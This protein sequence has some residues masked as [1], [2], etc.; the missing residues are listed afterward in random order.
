MIHLLIKGYLSAV[1]RMQIVFGLGEPF[2]ASWPLLECTLQ[3]IKL[4]Q[5]KR[6]VT[7]SQPRLP[8]RPSSARCATKRYIRFSDSG[9]GFDF[10][11]LQKDRYLLWPVVYT[12]AMNGA[13]AASIKSL[14]SP[15]RCCMSS[16]P[17][18]PGEPPNLVGSCF[19]PV[20]PGG[21]D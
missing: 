8:C 14:T 11:F 21:R 1:R 19:V 12:R 9:N 5:A 15:S 16:S 20:M 6:A 2:V 18:L 13:I 17:G 3:G 4:G 7:H 10:E